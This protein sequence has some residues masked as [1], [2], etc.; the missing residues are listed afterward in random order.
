MRDFFLSY[1]HEDLAWAEWIASTLSKEKHTVTIQAWD[2]M[3][4]SNFVLEMQRATTE[5]SRTIAVLSPDWLASVFT[6]PEWAA[7]F[8][9]DPAG[10]S[11]MLIPVRVRA[12]EP[13]GLL[14]SIVYCDL[15]GLGEVDAKKRLLRAV[16]R[17]PYRPDFV[18]FPPAAMGTQ[19]GPSRNV[20]VESLDEDEPF[21]QGFPGPRSTVAFA[22]LPSEVTCAFDLLGLVRTT[23]KTFTAQGRLRNQLVQR[24]HER[25]V[26]NP[27][28]RLQ[29]EEFFARYFAKFDDYE[30]QVF[31]TIRSFTLSILS[32]YNREI[33]DKIKGCPEL[34]G[35]IEDLPQLKQHLILWLA[36]FEG[37]FLHA[38]DMCL[39]YVGVEEGAPF[40]YDVEKEIWQFLEGRMDEGLVY[41]EELDEPYVGE[42][43]SRTERWRE[44]L[45]PKWILKR[46]QEL[47]AERTKI[48]A[49]DSSAM[50][51]QEP[52]PRQL[53]KNVDEQWAEV[54]SAALSSGTPFDEVPGRERLSSSLKGLIAC[55]DE[56]WPADFVAA[57]SACQATPAESCFRT[58]RDTLLPVLPILSFYVDTLGLESNL[59]VVWQ[60]LRKELESAAIL[61]CN[62][63]IVAERRRIT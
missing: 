55:R 25:L 42:G 52:S 7:A 12:C 28:Q 50:R 20:A 43:L 62:S 14:R 29:Y 37:V 2:F 34:L 4:G 49:A 11:R 27:Y 59:G 58:F 3:P 51:V 16:S 61:Y 35:E 33:L 1:N 36:K 56:H 48:L 54:L 22:G 57:L 9:L 10:A 32:N 53:L 40:P 39:L 13:P 23:R 21:E 17:Q 60:D 6:Q 26:L 8:V 38:P 46:I 44:R 15:V 18:V 45:Q 47:E 41:A 24:I 63:R 5:C 19:S 30:K 31:A